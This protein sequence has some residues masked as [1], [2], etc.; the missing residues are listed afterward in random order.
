[1]FKS[2]NVIILQTALLKLNCLCTEKK[3]GKNN[4]PAH[5]RVCFNEKQRKMY[6]KQPFSH[7]RRS[8]LHF[9]KIKSKPS[10]LEFVSLQSETIIKLIFV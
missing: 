3:F 9:E 2:Q 10:I 8:K 1:M 5:C 6:K 7:C 4:N